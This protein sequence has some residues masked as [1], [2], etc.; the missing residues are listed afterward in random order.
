M[1]TSLELS[2]QSSCEPGH[3]LFVFLVGSVELTD[4]GH[5]GDP[6]QQDPAAKQAERREDY[7]GCFNNFWTPGRQYKTEPNPHDDEGGSHQGPSSNFANPEHHFW[8]P[9]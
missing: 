5:S 4:P 6:D 3:R 9:A 2:T 8:F 7:D 1:K